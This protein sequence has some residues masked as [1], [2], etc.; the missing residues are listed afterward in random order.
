MCRSPPRS[1]AENLKDEKK[2]NRAIFLDRDGVIVVDAHLITRAEQISLIPGVPGALNKLNR[3][4][5]LLIV[6]SNQPVVARGL[7]SEEGVV[8]LNDEIDRRIVKSGGRAFDG[9][10]FCP[11]HPNATLPQYR[12]ACACRKPRPGL[13]VQAAKDHMIDLSM[14]FM[15]GDRVS[16]IIAGQRA[17]CRT[18][19]VHSGQH[20]EAPIESPDAIDEATQPDVVCADL[21]AAADWIG[22][23]V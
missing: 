10:Y 22:A 23:R 1:C 17:G 3:A 5:F 6:V 21:A 14:S 13:I 12:Q 2:V 7:L 18:I 8:A 4:G 20:A 16:D 15:V 11:H 19:L 9:F